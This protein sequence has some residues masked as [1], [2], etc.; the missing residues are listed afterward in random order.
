[1]KPIQLV[2]A[3]DHPVVREGLQKMLGNQPDFEIVG[4]ASTGA[5]A[6]KL[7]SQL[8]P[9]VVLMDLRMPDL[10]GAAATAKIRALEVKTSVLI[11]TTYESSVDILHAIEAGATGYLLKDAKKE[12][13]FSAIRTVARGQAILAPSVTT[14]LLHKVRTP[15]QITL[16][17]RE[18]EILALVARGASNKQIARTMRLSEATV[19]SHLLHLFEKL[20][21]S[22]RTAAV[23][24]ALEHGLLRLET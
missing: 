16:T 17:A 7:V 10:D 22:D 11:L 12:E 3:D 14:W 2:I 9:D 21:V 18:E 5:E 4:E 13:L 24:A 19:K 23:T 20:N 8:Q 15:A 6:V 1:M